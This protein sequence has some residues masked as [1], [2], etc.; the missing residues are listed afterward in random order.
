MG[1]ENIGTPEAENIKENQRTTTRQ[2][3]LE[4]SDV[5]ERTCKPAHLARPPVDRG[6]IGMLSP[7]AHSDFNYIGEM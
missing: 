6:R 2:P 1:Q 3:Q 7:A 4:T 5:A